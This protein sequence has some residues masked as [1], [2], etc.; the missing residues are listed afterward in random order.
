MDP[1]SI[2]GAVAGV[3]SAFSAGI[4]VVK[5]WRKH[6][7]RKQEAKQLENLLNESRLV[8]QQDCDQRLRELGS[9]FERGDGK[10]HTCR[11]SSCE[12][13]LN[14]QRYIDNVTPW[15]GR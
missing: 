12:K 13:F 11:P 7:E 15:N 14:I 9:L 5:T 10:H 3:I 1:L 6:R 2:V 8:I 4:S